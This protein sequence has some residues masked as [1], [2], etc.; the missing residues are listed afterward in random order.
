MHNVTLAE[1]FT[2]AHSIL[3][4]EVHTL[5]GDQLLGIFLR[6]ALGRS[7]RKRSRRATRFLGGQGGFLTAS[8]VMAA[9]GVAWGLYDSMKTAAPAAAGA[10][11]PPPPPAAPLVLP[12]DVARVVRLA[13]SAAGADGT[14]ADAERAVILRHAREAGIADHVETELARPRPLTEIVAGVTADAERRDLYALAFTIVRADEAVSGAERIYLAQLAHAL[15]LDPATAAALEQQT[16]PP[17]TAPHRHRRRRRSRVV[18]AGG[19]HGAAC[20][21]T[22]VVRARRPHG[23]GAAMQGAQQWYMAIG[24]HQ[25]GPVSQ[26]EILANLRNGSIDKEHAG[27]HLGDGELAAAEGRA[28]LLAVRSTRRRSAGV[29][30]LPPS[31]PGRRAHD[32]DFTIHGNEMQFVEVELDPGEARGRRGRVDDVHDRRRAAGDDLRRRQPL[33]AGRRARRVAR[34]RQ[35]PPHR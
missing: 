27:V 18:P 28:G 5:D 32:I 9:V 30:P 7:G 22:R 19:P 8:T 21:H 25:V 12:A 34:R 26:E 15:G 10:V 31:A 3:M 6:G 14:L 17:S 11:P 13:V 35:A 29:V 2:T 33:A 24:G 1:P 16:P 20:V 4:A 23:Q